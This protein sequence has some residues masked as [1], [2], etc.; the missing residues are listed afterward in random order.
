MTVTYYGKFNKNF[1]NMSDT[2]VGDFIPSNE[3]QIVKPGQKIPAGLHI[4]SNLQTGITEAK[5]LDKHDNKND[6]SGISLI[7]NRHYLRDR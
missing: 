7:W 5:L 4:R 3:W 2:T 6:E 1:I